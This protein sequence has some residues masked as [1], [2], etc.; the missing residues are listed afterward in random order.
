MEALMGDTHGKHLRQIPESCQLRD[1]AAANRKDSAGGISWHL[2]GRANNRIMPL[3][4]AAS[5][6]KTATTSPPAAL[7]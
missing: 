5:A 7:A 1:R 4:P 3:Y 2:R 6:D